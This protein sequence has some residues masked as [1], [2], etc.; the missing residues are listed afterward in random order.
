[1]SRKRSITSVGAHNR[2]KA[3]V[4]VASGSGSG[5]GGGGGV[6]APVIR[7]SV[8]RRRLTLRLKWRRFVN[9][10]YGRLIACA[11]FAAPRPM[12]FTKLCPEGGEHGTTIFCNGHAE[13]EHVVTLGRSM[14][15]GHFRSVKTLDLVS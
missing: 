7:A 12:V 4:V 2:V 8:I 5:G 14:A 1:M 9:V 11:M 15:A 13:N 6:T 10:D 3:A